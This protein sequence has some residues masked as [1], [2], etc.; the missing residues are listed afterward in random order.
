M[1]R[2]KHH[3]LSTS[4]APRRRRIRRVIR[5]VPPVRS[6]P[7]DRVLSQQELFAL[8]LRSNLQKFYQKVKRYESKG[9]LPDGGVWYFN[10]EKLW[11]STVQELIIDISSS[12]RIHP[13]YIQAQ[14]S[15]EYLGVPAINMATPRGW[16]PKGLKNEDK[17]MVETHMQ[18]T[19][20]YCLEKFRDKLEER[21][22]LL[23]W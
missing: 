18:V 8:E 21:L 1:R 4:R 9:G 19:I 7:M 10:P 22:E 16:I 11:L 5:S 6:I 3:I 13:S 15:K 20:K 14:A 23:G 2:R 12:L 17:H